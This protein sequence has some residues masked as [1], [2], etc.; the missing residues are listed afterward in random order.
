MR[1]LNAISL[2]S[3]SGIGDLGLHANGINTV[4]ACEL[5]EERM[6]LFQTNNPN[7]KCFCGDIWELKEDIIENYRTRF[8][9][10]PF[11]ILATPPCQGMSPNGMGK[12]LSDYR[13]GLRPKYD[14]RNRLIIPAIHIIKELKP[15]WIVFENVSNMGNTLIYDE[16]DELVNIIDYVRRELGDEYIGGPQVIDC[17]DFGV[18]EHRIR[19]LTV[20][21]KTEKAHKHYSAYSTF[22]PERTHSQEGDLFTEPWITL[23]DA[24]G[25]QKPLRAIKGENVDK[26]NPLH[27]VHSL[28][29]P[30]RAKGVF[31]MSEDAYIKLRKIKFFDGRPA[32]Q[33]SLIE[34]EPERLFGCDVYVSDYMPTV[35]GGNKPVLFGDFEYYWIGDRGKR[36]FKRLSER[37][38]DHGLVGF[39]ATQR[40]DGTLVLPEA[41]KSLVVKS[42]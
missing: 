34:G 27:M 29:A 28:K 12:M 16:N 33:P 35:D 22:L 21:S 26:E 24:I 20:F 9:E 42:E 39:V 37:F 1:N 40:M 15:K 10:E 41:V 3:S 8:S 31:V 19:L 36:R 14:E 32:W 18:P 5:L 30:Y 25:D 38:A 13:K 6:N 4:I 11:L 2:F 23:K 17:A 7:T